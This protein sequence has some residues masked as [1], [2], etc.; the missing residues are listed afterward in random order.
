MPLHHP[1]PDSKFP[2]I[3]NQQKNRLRGTTLSLL[4]FRNWSL[5]NED[6][7]VSGWLSQLLRRPWAH[8]PRW[9]RYRGRQ[10]H[11][12][13]RGGIAE[14]FGASATAPTGAASTSRRILSSVMLKWI[15]GKCVWLSIH[16]LWLPNYGKVSLTC[17]TAVGEGQ[18]QE[19]QIC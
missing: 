6:N 11:V 12:A 17:N 18:D 15:A 7:F 14:S 9:N 1:Q 4:P 19:L 5:S 13:G 8:W 10:M 16:T 2:V 3:V